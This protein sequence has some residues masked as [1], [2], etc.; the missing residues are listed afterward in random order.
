VSNEDWR[1]I[2]NAL[3]SDDFEKAH[4]LLKKGLPSIEEMNAR[5]SV[6]WRILHEAALKGK[7]QLA[8]MLI[9]GGADVNGKTKNG[10]TPLHHAAYNGHLE[11][12]KFL[13][14]KGAIVDETNDD[15][16]TPLEWAIRMGH[17]EVASYLRS[18]GDKK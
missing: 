9:K 6:G 2:R 8:E 17:E 13:I 1:K 3:K 18:L 11:M 14:S 7:L 12:A 10:A 15:G 4:D 5:D 16:E